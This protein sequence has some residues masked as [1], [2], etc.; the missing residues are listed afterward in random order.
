MEF[1]NTALVLLLISFT[2]LNSIFVSESSPNIHKRYFGFESD[3]YADVGKILVM[4]LGLNAFTANAW[5]FKNFVLIMWDRFKD[6]EYN[7]N[8][9]KYPEE[10]EDDEPNTKKVQ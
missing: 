2:P 7:V 1:F 10:D 9:K 5:Q 8:L 4:T 3:W 6:R